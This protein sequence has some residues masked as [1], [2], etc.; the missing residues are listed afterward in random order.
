MTY[1]IELIMLAPNDLFSN[2]HLKHL[3]LEYGD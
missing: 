1:F 2:I 3:I